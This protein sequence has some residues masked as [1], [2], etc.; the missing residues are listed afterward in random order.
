[1]KKYLIGS[2]LISLLFSMPLY[3]AV[4]NG[5]NSDYCYAINGTGTTMYN[6]A[7]GAN[8]GT[9]AVA[10]ET[11]TFSGSPTPGANSP[12]GAR[13]FTAAAYDRSGNGNADDIFIQEWDS[14]GNM[15][16]KSYL[17]TAVGGYLSFDATK[18]LVLGTIRYNQANNTLIVSA[19]VA[20]K[21]AGGPKASKAWEF[22]LPDWAESSTAQPVSLVNTYTML[23]NYKN[24]TNIDV[25][26]DGTMYTTGYTYGSATSGR[27]SISSTPT[28]PSDPNF[29]VNTVLL[30]GP[31][32]F[33]NTGDTQHYQLSA[34]TYRE[35]T[36]GTQEILTAN[37]SVSTVYQPYAWFFGGPGVGGFGPTPILSRKGTPGADIAPAC[38]RIRGIRAQTDPLTG[39]SFMV[40]N[41]GGSNSGVLQVRPILPRNTGSLVF[42]PTNPYTDAASPVPEP[43]TLLLLG[44][45]ALPLLRRRR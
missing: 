42:D 23:T 20:N 18:P 19:N 36:D 22:G 7:D 28:N 39:E 31:T 25:G 11:F 15:I 21:H 45:G 14:A 17:Y 38:D 13:M 30:D 44:L 43:A 37:E 35:L 8:M 26:P 2:V 9:L 4:S 40:G 34:I 6:Q 41:D 12:K 3:A 27:S 1:M 5:F 32:Y 29:G 24:R 16:R 10:G 33:N